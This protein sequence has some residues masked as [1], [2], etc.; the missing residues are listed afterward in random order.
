MVLLVRSL[1]AGLATVLLVVGAVLLFRHGVRPNDFPPYAT[2]TTRTVI[3][4]YS[5]PWIGAAAFAVLL[6][7]LCATSCGTDAI[8][9]VR[10][11]RSRSRH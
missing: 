8:G 4:R 1:L 9:R 5:G 3:R 2:G 7:G 10:L 6:A 11:Q